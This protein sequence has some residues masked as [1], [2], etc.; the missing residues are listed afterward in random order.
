MNTR[1]FSLGAFAALGIF[2]TTTAF[3]FNT[4]SLDFT[5]SFEGF[6]APSVWTTTI[7]GNPSY[8]ASPVV[9]TDGAPDAVELIGA[10]GDG[11]VPQV[12]SILDYS[13][14]VPGTDPINVSFTYGFYDPISTQDMAQVLDNGVVVATLNSHVSQFL[15][16]G[17][18]K[19]GD[20]LDFRLT[21]DIVNLP[22]SLE[23]A[24]IPEPSTLALVMLA[25]AAFV[26]KL[27][28]RSIGR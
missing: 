28:Y 21:S 22:D 4:P 16:S 7:S 11:T 5:G 8:V 2:F 27:R 20:V 18:F 3:A 23:I 1:S 26:L 14:T 25:G 9:V 12:L 24:P 17:V 19:G 6:Y 15:L 13:T 10:I